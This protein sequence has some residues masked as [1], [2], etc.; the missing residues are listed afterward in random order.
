MAERARG[1]EP[2]VE[3]LFQQYTLDRDPQ[4]RDQLIARHTHLVEVVAKKFSGMGEPS[5]DLVQE[6]RLGLINAVNMF[7]VGRGVKF[8]TYATHLIAGQIQHYLRD[9]GKLI[10]QPAWVQELLAKIT[11]T[12]EAL[13]QELGRA[14][15]DA[16]VAERLNLTP[17]AVKELLDAR[18][19][20]KVSSLDAQ[21]D[22]DTDSPT[23]VINPDKIRSAH[24]VSLQLPIEDKLMLQEA[25]DKL[26]DLERKV[27]RYFFYYDL[28]QTEIARKLEISV[29]Y[30]SYLLRG[31][32]A[33]LR[34]NFERQA[35]VE[36]ELKPVPAMGPV[37]RGR[38]PEAG[39]P[40]ARAAEGGSGLPG[41]SY[42]RERLSQEVDRAARYPV[43]F[44]LVVVQLD[45]EPGGLLPSAL[46]G[47]VGM[48]LRRS[49]RSVDAVAVRE[50]GS[51]GLLLPHTGKEA[52]ILAERLLSRIVATDWSAQATGRAHWTASVGYAVYPHDANS[53]AGLL[54]AAEQAV[55]AAAQAGGGTVCSSPAQV[56]RPAAARR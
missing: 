29:N 53:E 34:T 44:A 18:E 26:K 6:G 5:E 2:S 9:K 45:R 28:N 3:V 37:A 8:S 20:T 47:A 13:I 38:R 46:V 7:D 11:R 42:L 1:D 24:L 54:E 49:T 39:V 23:A 12:T 14:P 35:Q 22:A 41:E 21:L 10:R 56:R 4:L 55:Q 43:Q 32:L 40:L 51:Y 19:R 16:E 30:A 17:A 27:V 52:R 36:S 15:T 25:I 33:K 48:L 31:A 50:A